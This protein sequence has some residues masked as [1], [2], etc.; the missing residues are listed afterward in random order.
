M[1]GWNQQAIAVHGD[2]VFRTDRDSA[3]NGHLLFALDIQTG[4]E[5]WQKPFTYRAPEGVGAPSVYGTMVY[6][7]RAGHSGNSAGPYEDLPKLYGLDVATGGE[8]FVE[9]YSAQWGSNERPTID[10]NQLVTESGY[11]GGMSSYDPTAG[12]KQWSVYKTNAND[13]PNAAMDDQYVYAFDDEVYDRSTGDFIC[14]LTHPDG[15]SL[16]GPIVSSSGTVVLKSSRGAAAFDATTHALLWDFATPSSV[17]RTA[18][19]NGLVALTAGSHLYL[20]D[21]ETGTELLDWDAGANLVYRDLVLT[22]SH[23]FVQTTS[24]VIAVDLARG[25]S[26]WTYPAAGE[27]AYSDGHLFLSTPDAVIAF[28]PVARGGAIFNDAGTVVITDSTLSGNTADG[29]Q[30]GAVFNLNGSVTIA[31]ST[32]T[33]N[34][35]DRG[36]RGIFSLADGASAAVTID[37]SIVAQDNVD[38]TDVEIETVNGGSSSTS[39]DWNIIGSSSG[40]EGNVV[41]TADPLLGPLQDNGGPTWTHLPCLGS[42]AIDAGNPSDSLSLDQRERTRPWDADSDGNAVID[43]GAV[44]IQREDLSWDFGDAPDTQIGT[45]TGNY[46]TL[47]ANGGPAHVAV[48]PTLGSRRDIEPDG[49]PTAG[50]DG[51]DAAGSPDDEDGIKLPT[52]AVSSAAASI[53]SVVVDL[54]NA[55]TTANYLD[56]WIDFNGDGD[57]HDPGEQIFRSYDLGTTNGVRSLAFAVPQDTGDNIV[58]GTTYARFRLSTAGGLAPTGAAADGEV[59]DL[60]VTLTAETIAADKPGICRGHMWYLDA[61]GSNGWS[62]SADRWLGFGT[63]GDEPVVGDWNGD[64]TDEIGVYRSTTGMWYL[65]TDGNGRWDLPGDT[66]FRFGVPGDT[67]VVGDWNG[68]GTDQIGVYRS[69]T[70]MWYLDTDG[71]GRWNVPGD[72]YFRFGVPG[73]TPV[74]GDWN[75]DGTDQIGVYRSATGGW[76]LDIDD[77][78]QWNMPGDYH[79]YFGIPGDNPVV[80]DWNGDGVDEIGVHRSATGKWYLDADGDYRWSLPGD[81]HF[82]FGIPGDAPVIGRWPVTTIPR[83]PAN[84]GGAAADASLSASTPPVV[85]ALPPNSGRSTRK[86]E[87]LPLAGIDAFFAAEIALPQLTHSGAAEETAEPLAAQATRSRRRGRSPQLIRSLALQDQAIVDLLY[88]DLGEALDT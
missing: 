66:R 23:V 75:G 45:G 73:D 86:Q 84:A 31:N 22:R 5:L 65:D 6:V 88:S 14:N 42:P 32:L 15:W 71:N 55:D 33:D 20:I 50:A 24:Q 28:V 46:N 8:V 2:R 35:A 3:S 1:T 41:S 13:R 21:Q 81:S 69:G 38:V 9:T 64:G 43:V 30:G 10:G 60:L 34:S 52:L 29:G 37:S 18:I 27:L 59:E 85:L 57:W 61:D 58:Y 39:G 11:F 26:S 56:A 68:D 79:G 36:G 19:G 62:A 16:D 40:F 74:V 7:S 53:A 49:Q 63:V 72:T 12:T 67:S 48:G 44:E 54:Q 87:S 51:D 78:D 83:E 17:V 77:N 70:S 76:Y 82:R 80:G 4:A 25:Q 47:W